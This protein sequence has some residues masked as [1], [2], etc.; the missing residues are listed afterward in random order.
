[1]KQKRAIW[2]QRT[3]GWV[4]ARQLVGL[5][6]NSFKAL[7]LQMIGFYHCKARVNIKIKSYER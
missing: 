5:C 1:M 2:S 6:F 3:L 4:F 7:I